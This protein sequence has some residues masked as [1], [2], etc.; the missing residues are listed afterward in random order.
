MNKA[1]DFVSRLRRSEQLIGY[2]SL[3]DAQVA[4]ERLARVGYDYICVDAQHGL[5]DYK[6]WLNSLMAIDAGAQLGP[7]PTVGMVRVPANDV[8]WIGQALDAGAAGVIVPLINTAEDAVKAAAAAHY[9]PIGVRSFGPMRAQLRVSN[10][11]AEANDSLACIA[12]IETPQAL[13]NVAEIAAVPGIDALYIGPSD[14]RIAVGG[15]SSTDPTVDGVF[16]DALRRVK[17]ESG[18]LPVG[19]HT[20]SGEVAK[21]RL[22]DGFDFVTI[23]SDLVHLEQVSASHLSVARS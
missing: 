14:L 8:T 9:P 10:V 13:E 19:I 2:W 3:M 16:S 11:L 1:M 23:A 6:A 22:A 7:K 17:E 15:A 12:M 4:V 20:P 21:A 5:V 18:N